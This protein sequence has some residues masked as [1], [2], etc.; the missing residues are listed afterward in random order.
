MSVDALIPIRPELTPASM[1]NDTVQR[2]AKAFADR[3][4]VSA[5]PQAAALVSYVDALINALRAGDLAA[6]TV[7]LQSLEATAHR[8]VDTFNEWGHVHEKSVQTF[9]PAYWK[10]LAP[11]RREF[12]VLRTMSQMAT[13]GDDTLRGN[14]AAHRALCTGGNACD[15]HEA[16]VRALEARGIRI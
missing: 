12:A 5:V 8:L 7:G 15:L 14:Y 11:A 1:P 16:F 9:D 2:I 4:S 6:F 13:W 3:L 10:A